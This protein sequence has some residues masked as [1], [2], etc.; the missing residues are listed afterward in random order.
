VS[1]RAKIRG[2]VRLALD[3]RGATNERFAA[4]LQ[5]CRRAE[6][7]L[8]P[9]ESQMPA[10]RFKRTRYTGPF[11]LA[12]Q[13]SQ[14]YTFVRWKHDYSKFGI[15][16]DVPKSFVVISKSEA[17]WMSDEEKLQTLGCCPSQP[18]A[19]WFDILTAIP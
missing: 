13:T 17:N 16:G 2:L 14:L 5:V 10:Q 7:L 6:E 12:S 4:A 8:G 1:D 18:V 3:E 11:Y 15:P 9:D 19:W